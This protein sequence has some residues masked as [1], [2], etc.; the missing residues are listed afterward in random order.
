MITIQNEEAIVSKKQWVL[1][2]VE[3]I[4]ANNIEGGIFAGQ[5][6]SVNIKAQSFPPS[7][8]HTFYTHGTMAS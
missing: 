3:L 8:I 1:P 5:K 2:T 7:G 4:A 6:E